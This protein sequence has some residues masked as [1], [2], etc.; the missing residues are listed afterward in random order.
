MKIRGD[1]HVLAKFLDE[2]ITQGDALDL[3]AHLPRGSIDLFF[4]SPPYAD[5]RA[6][7]RI[8]PDHYVAW[9]LPFAKAMYHAAKA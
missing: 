9:F 3:L 6:Y 4:T 8:H 7:S 5:A 2:G 1:A